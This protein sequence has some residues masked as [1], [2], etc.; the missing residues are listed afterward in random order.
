MVT[1]SLAQSFA[2]LHEGLRALHA[3]LNQLQIE[4]EQYEQKKNKLYLALKGN[5]LDQSLFQLYHPIPVHSKE[6]LREARE[7]VKSCSR[8]C[9]QLPNRVSA[10]ALPHDEVELFNAHVALLEEYVSR[11]F[12][13]LCSRLDALEQLPYDERVETVSQI[14]LLCVNVESEV[15]DF[16]LCVQLLFTAIRHE[17]HETKPVFTIPVRHAL[18]TLHLPAD[19]VVLIDADFLVEVDRQ[20]RELSRVH[21]QQISF[22]IDAPQPIRLL[23]RIE[24]ELRHTAMTQQGPRTLVSPAFLGGLLSRG[25]LVQESHVPSSPY[26]ATELLGLWVQCTPQGRQAQQA[27]YGDTITQTAT[28]VK[29]VH[30]GDVALLSY[31][32][33]RG[34]RP[35]LILTNNTSEF[36][37]LSREL[38]QKGVAVY[39]AS[40]KD[41]L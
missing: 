11:D 1:V 5:R 8:I 31:A 2:S 33:E 26:Y 4:C 10:G 38:R 35:T 16:A 23:N 13:D 36:V 25:L 27:S 37:P 7:L 32:W 28:G 17:Q 6:S 20:Q 19:T 41:I 14:L 24:E 22:A 39:T 21:Q 30:S 40:T 12:S 15:H 3:R 9:P 29:F 18:E 34:Q